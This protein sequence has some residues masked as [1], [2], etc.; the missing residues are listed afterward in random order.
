MFKTTNYRSKICKI[1]ISK[2]MKYI[3]W[4]YAS[5]LPYLGKTSVCKDSLNFDSMA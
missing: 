3:K 4:K 2:D 5:K 1:T